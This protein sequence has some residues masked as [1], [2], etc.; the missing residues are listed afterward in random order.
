[1]R[2]RSNDEKRAQAAPAPA[3]L[4]MGTKVERT[5]TQVVA[6]LTKEFG[7]GAVSRLSDEGAYADV[8]KIV[9]TGLPSLDAALG[10]GGIPLGKVIEIY[11]PEHSG[12]SSLAK[13]I[14][15]ACQLAGVVP[16][17]N[18]VENAGSVVHSA[19]HGI[20]PEWALGSQP[21][22][23]EDVFGRFLTSMP[24][25]CK[26][27]VYA[28]YDWD[29]LAATYTLKELEAEVDEEVRMALRAS[30]LA[31]NLPKLRPHLKTGYVGLLIVNQLREKV[32][33]KPWEKQT[34]SPGGRA[35]RHEAAIRIEIRGSGYLK[36]GDADPYGLK[37]HGKV[38]KN[39]CAPP[40]REFD[41]ELHFNPPRLVDPATPKPAKTPLR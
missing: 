23:M 3:A 41:L 21:D 12:K 17:E 27:G 34:Y 15:G 7:P 28:F 25:F 19:A 9:P 2:K 26:N 8:K 20:R 14:M 36:Q 38:V 24:I 11:G 39:K 22:T 33:A 13:H 10:V 6:V 32:G 16:F 37:M 1:M 35:L 40:L 5:I 18:D 31:K 29:S 4:D 30:F